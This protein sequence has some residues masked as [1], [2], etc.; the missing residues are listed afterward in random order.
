MRILESNFV[1]FEPAWRADWVWGLQLIVL[2]VV[3]HILCLGPI[4]IGAVRAYIRTSQ[5]YSHMTRFVVVMGTTTLLATIL[6]GAEA[7]LW[8]AAYRFLGALPDNR[9][10]VLYSLNAITSYG[11]TRL[12]LEAR[13]ELMGALESLNGW[14]LFGLTTA[15]FFATIEKV[16]SVDESTSNR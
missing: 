14:L 4:R 8:A 6:H 13:W 2:T 7:S 9:S 10:A 11:H 12:Q 16:W 1:A 3:L 15:F 5:R